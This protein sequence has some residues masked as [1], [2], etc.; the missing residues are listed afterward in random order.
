MWHS[1]TQRF[2][3]APSACHWLSLQLGLHPHWCLANILTSYWILTS[4]QHIH[5]TSF[6]LVLCQRA[7]VLLAVL[8]TDLLGERTCGRASLELAR[9]EPLL[10][11]LL[12]HPSSSPLVFPQ[13]RGN[14]GHVSSHYYC[15]KYLAIK[16]QLGC[17]DGIAGKM[18]SP[19]TCCWVR[20]EQDG[21]QETYHT[22]R[23]AIKI[24][25]I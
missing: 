5:C 3:S 16:A 7:N 19:N 23:K 12:F 11:P 9:S 10:H 8:E 25:T 14:P 13:L 1:S 15:I 22:V 24:S 6:P 18:P 17:G 20:R 2:V 4:L 21:F